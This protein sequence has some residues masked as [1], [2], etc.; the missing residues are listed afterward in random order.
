MLK[1][2]FRVVELSLVLHPQVLSCLIVDSFLK[3]LNIGGIEHSTYIFLQWF[4]YLIIIIS[5]A[6]TIL[7]VHIMRYRL[8]KNI[9][10]Q[11]SFIVS[12]RF[13]N[14][15]VR[16]VIHCRDHLLDTMEISV[17]LVCLQHAFTH[18]FIQI[19]FRFI[20]LHTNTIYSITKRIE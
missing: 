16:L 9:I 19:I 1:Y 10:F 17:Q 4:D 7:I 3:P 6:L 14:N 5:L 20:L 8:Y 15:C 11:V 2:V 13:S 18:I 12:T